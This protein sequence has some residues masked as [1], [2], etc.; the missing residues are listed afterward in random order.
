[1]GGPGQLKYNLEAYWLMQGG[2]WQ[3]ICRHCYSPVFSTG[4]LLNC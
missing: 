3:L 1:M 4:L 2:N